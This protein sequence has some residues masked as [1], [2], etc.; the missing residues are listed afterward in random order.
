L[1]EVEDNYESLPEWSELVEEMLMQK[2]HLY[3]LKEQC[4]D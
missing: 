2:R 3:Y 4:E 1:D